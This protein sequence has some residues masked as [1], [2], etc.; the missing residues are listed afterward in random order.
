MY[1][2]KCS[3]LIY[4][5]SVGFHTDT[6]KVLLPNNWSGSWEEMVFRFCTKL[7]IQVR[8]RCRQESTYGSEYIQKRFIKSIQKSIQMELDW[9]R[10]SIILNIENLHIWLDSSCDVPRCSG[11]DDGWNDGSR[12][13][14]GLLPHRRPRPNPPPV[15][16]TQN[17]N[18]RRERPDG[19]CGFR[20]LTPQWCPYVSL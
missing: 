14:P 1:V 12:S 4:I 7:E 20:L 9:A 19:L 3:L 18:Y 8:S 5:Q 15:Q 13:E 2:A 10:W 11:T 17:Q 16:H 6:I